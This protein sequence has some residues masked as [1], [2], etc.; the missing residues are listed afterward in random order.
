MKRFKRALSKVLSSPHAS[1]VARVLLFGALASCPVSEA[2]QQAPAERVA[3]EL[4]TLRPTGFDVAHITRR[5]GSFLLAVNNRTG[6]TDEVVLRLDR[7]AGGRF[8]AA[9]VSRGEG[10]VR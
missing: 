10:G 2:Q 9:K 1:F 5:Y 4:V 8:V 7:V 6:L 3:V